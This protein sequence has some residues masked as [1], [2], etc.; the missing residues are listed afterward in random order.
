[1]GKRDAEG[2]TD[3]NPQPRPFKVRNTIRARE[4]RNGATPA[5]RKLWAYL[6]LSQLGAKFSRQIQLG[7]FFVDFV[8]RREQLIVEIDGFSHDVAP[9]RDVSRDAYLRRAG[10][11]VLHFSNAD[12]SDNVEGVVE[13]IR[14]AL[15]GQ[16][17][18]NPSRLREGL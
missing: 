2:G 13:A 4:L 9:E 1:M 10:Y 7:P 16:P 18:P 17:H 14:V 15:G 3:P 8:S 11:R 5:E 6:S 12:V